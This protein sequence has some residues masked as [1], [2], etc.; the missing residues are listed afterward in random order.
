MDLAKGDIQRE[1]EKKKN[2]LPERE[3]DRETLY[4]KQKTVMKENI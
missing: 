2:T 3:K 4:R 1:I